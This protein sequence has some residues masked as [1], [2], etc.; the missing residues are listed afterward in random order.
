MDCR[1]R[2]N[3]Y[4]GVTKELLGMF[5]YAHPL[6]KLTAIQTYACALYGSNLWDLYGP[7]ASQMFTC[8][9]ISV[10]DAWGVSRLTRTYIV[11]HLL[12]CS[13]PPIRQLVIRRYIGFVQS[14]VTSKNPVIS[15]LSNWAVNTVRSN[16][17]LNLFNIRNE[18]ER[19]P[20][21]YGSTQFSTKKKDIPE[22]CEE[23]IVLLSNLLQQREEEMDPDIVLEL[24]IVINNVCTR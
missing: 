21:L 11:D 18:F 9:N 16:T 20:L 17:G 6:Q 24:D 15:T 1:L 14:L 12:S 23:N 19:D 8:W 13:L 3:A 10:R 7:A 22:N 5:K 2:R 4:I